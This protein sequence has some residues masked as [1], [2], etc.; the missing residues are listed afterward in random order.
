MQKTLVVGM[1][2]LL[3]GDDGVGVHAV[4]RLAQSGLPPGVEAVDIGTNSYDLLDCLCESAK[5][6][7]I[8]AME[9]G[10]EPGTI[11]RV[12]LEELRLLRKGDIVSS[13]QIHFREAVE[14]ARM[15]GYSPQITVIGVEPKRLD[16]GTEL[17]PEVEQRMPRLLELIRREIEKI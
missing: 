14:M 11:Y 4:R 6:I 8:D 5:L 13:H 17:S 7:V 3:L 10:R 9:G 15:M 12:P 2:N 16:W 1:G